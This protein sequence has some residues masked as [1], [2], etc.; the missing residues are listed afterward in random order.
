MNEEA[1]KAVE[2][3]K[4]VFNNDAKT[5]ARLDA[6]LSDKSDERIIAF[7]AKDSDKI[8]KELSQ[9]ESRT[10]KKNKPVITT[11]TEVTTTEKQSTF[12]EVIAMYASNNR[13][14]T[15][16]D[17]QEADVIIANLE[18]LIG[19]VKEVKGTKKDAHIQKLKEEEERLRKEIEELSKL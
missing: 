11:S 17:F 8:K 13:K 7:C 1:K 18:K 12:A 2:K 14:V 16:N 19:K 9:W 4:E 5:I 3:V 6:Y 15:F 10:K